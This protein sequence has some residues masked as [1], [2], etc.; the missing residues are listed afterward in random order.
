M[1]Y[2][3]PIDGIGIF[4][5]GIIQ[6]FFKKMKVPL[7]KVKVNGEYFDLDLRYRETSEF[8]T[9][10]PRFHNLIAVQ[11]LCPAVGTEIRFD[12]VSELVPH[13]VVVDKFVDSGGIG[14]SYYRCKN[15]D[16]NDKKIN[17]GFSNRSDL[18]P[19]YEAILIQFEKK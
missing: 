4:Q 6:Y 5:L 3:T 12:G 17:V 19:I 9:H 11:G 15:T 16:K 10:F 18:N 8:D 13:S 1:I 7:T 14:Y 2:K